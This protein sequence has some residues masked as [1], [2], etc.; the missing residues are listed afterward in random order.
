MD[1]CDVFPADK[2]HDD[3]ERNKACMHTY[4]FHVL[5]IHPPLSPPSP[6]I[7]WSKTDNLLAVA[8]DNGKI[9]FFADEVGR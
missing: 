6:Y 9:R 4:T 8:Y 3:D 5:T 2:T 7:A 1:K